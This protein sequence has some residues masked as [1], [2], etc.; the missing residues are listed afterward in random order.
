MS[1]ISGY[2]VRKELFG[3][4]SITAIIPK[5]FNDTAAQV[6]EE[7]PWM[8]SVLLS[9]WK[10]SQGVSVDAL[11]LQTSYWKFSESWFW[12]KMIFMG[13]NFPFLSDAITLPYLTC[14]Q[15]CSGPEKGQKYEREDLIIPPSVFGHQFLSILSSR[16]ILLLSQ[17]KYESRIEI[18]IKVEAFK[19]K[20]GLYFLFFMY[21]Y[22]SLS[23]FNIDAW[24]LS[25][26]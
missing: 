18:I 26:H 10:D 12:T 17:K 16:G 5:L 2:S 8:I 13:S 6:S 1:W 22:S 14:R 9:S 7:P 20:G 19:E 4:Q 23:L 24:L 11:G 3:G 15:F 25:I 21:F